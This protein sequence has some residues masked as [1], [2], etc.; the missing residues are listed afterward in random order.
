LPT[1]AL[2]RKPYRRSSIDSSHEYIVAPAINEHQ[3]VAFFNIR[4]HHIFALQFHIGKMLPLT[5]LTMPD[6]P[7]ESE[8]ERNI[9]IKW[10]SRS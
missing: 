10:R 6:Y 2:A 1:R 4:Q 8:T 7:V 5:N 9:C 3:I